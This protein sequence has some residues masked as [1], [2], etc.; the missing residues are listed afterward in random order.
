MTAY[1]ITDTAINLVVS[2]Q[3]FSLTRNSVNGRKLIDAIREGRSEQELLDIADSTTYINAEGGGRVVVKSGTVLYN[4]ESMPECLVRRL[5]DMLAN[6]LP[7]QHLVNFYDRLDKNPSRRAVQELY[8]FLENKNIPITADGKLLMYKAVRQDYKDKH[9]GTFCN[10]PGE[11]LIM[12]R[13]DVCDDA[14]IG[15]SKGFHAGSLEYVKDFA[16]G[17]GTEG[18]DRIVLVEV[19]PADVVS[20]PK[21]CQCQKLRTCSYRVL[22]EFQG[23]LPEGGV[24]DVENPYMDSFDDD[25]DAPRCPNCGMRYDEGHVE[26]EIC[27]NPRCHRY[28][29]DEDNGGED[30]EIVLTR[31]EYEAALEAARNGR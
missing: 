21:D 30:E 14:D 22:Q 23:E 10:K 24:R 9:S 12:K 31:A 2:G 4:G 8:K 29:N 19:D 13:H 16:C 11:T 25:D 1:T 15:C 7:V 3:S 17:Y 6:N 5:L 27:T 18:G 26:L 20:I 28:L